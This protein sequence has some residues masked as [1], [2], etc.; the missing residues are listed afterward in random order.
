VSERGRNVTRSCLFLGLVLV[1]ARSADGAE[2]PSVQDFN[3]SFAALRDANQRPG[4]GAR[5]PLGAAKVSMVTSGGPTTSGPQIINAV[6][7]WATAG[8]Q[9]VGL[10]TH[11]WS[12]GERFEVLVHSAAPVRIAL[13]YHAPGAAPKLVF[14]DTR[15][16]ETCVVIPADR[17][18]KFP[19]P[20]EMEHT[21]Q[22]ER[23]S[24][25]I[26]HAGSP[27]IADKS[28]GARTD[29][30]W[31]A[32]FGKLLRPLPPDGEGSKS[33]GVEFVKPSSAAISGS[34]E[35][36]QVHLQ[37]SGAVAQYTVTLKKN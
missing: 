16:P 2:I 6:K 21:S 5:A 31:S 34:P 33:F 17:V 7:I 1:A 19:Y 28:D 26:V 35:A 8:A 14:P 12:A 3:A 9:N 11:R 10:E 24:I 37:G 4:P 27:T 15:Y 30:E 29:A 18:Y 20:F 13:F 22:D 32:Q 23:M 36:V 25:I